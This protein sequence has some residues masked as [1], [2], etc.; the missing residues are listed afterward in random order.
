MYNDTIKAENKIISNQDLTDIF[1]LMGDTLKKYLK[2]YEMEERQ[3]SVL[4]HSNQK[5]SF[6]DNGSR[7]KATIDF[8]DDT[9]ITID[10]YDNFASVFYNRGSEIKSLDVFFYLDYQVVNPL[11]NPKY[12]YYNQSIIM[13]I[14]ETKMEIVIKL[15]SKDNKLNEVYDFIK[16]KILSAPT[17]YD[18]IIKDRNKI[19]STVAFSTG[20]IPASII[21]IIPLF[22]PSINMLF[23]RGYIVYPIVALILSYL[24]GMIIS[25][26]KLDIYYKNLMPEKI[27]DGYDRET[28]K[29]I[30]KDDIK[31]YTDT[32]EIGFGKYLN[33][34]ENRENIKKMYEKYKSKLLTGIIV[35]LAITV[36]VIAVGLFI[37]FD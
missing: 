19:Y 36:L 34:L 6:K 33:S 23:F 1:G 12:Q 28:G 10:N 24:I 13:Y 16:N 5:Y 15:D 7:F 29:S 37:N 21:S 26:N 31:K 18:F 8:Y 25:S 32:S 4:D 11:A 27:Y 35:L 3:N 9:T 30:Y 2:I 22:I 14:K 20:L 17:K